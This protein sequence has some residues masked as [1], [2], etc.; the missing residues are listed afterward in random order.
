[1]DMDEQL[2]AAAERWRGQPLV[3]IVIDHAAGLVARLEISLGYTITNTDLEICEMLFVVTNAPPES[4]VDE[5]SYWRGSVELAYL[6]GKRNVMAISVGDIV[7]I[8]KKAYVCESAG[9]SDVATAS[10]S[11]T[12]GLAR[13]EMDQRRSTVVFER[14]PDSWV[15]TIE[16]SS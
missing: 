12:S 6:K 3:E 9:W 5:Q 8:G 2:R 7:R 15:I 4:L 1:M 10:R 13:R 14:D 11:V 16:E